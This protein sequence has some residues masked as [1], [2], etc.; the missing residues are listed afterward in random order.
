MPNLQ[1]TL[2][3]DVGKWTVIHTKA[4]SF[5]GKIESINRKGITVLLPNVYDIQHP[6]VKLVKNN[7]NV[8]AEDVSG[9][10]DSF[11]T[12]GFSLFFFPFLFLLPFL[13]FI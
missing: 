12:S 8:K 6:S 1:Q 7:I 10:Q 4:G 13:F 5:H 9:A 2:K 11:R 3:R